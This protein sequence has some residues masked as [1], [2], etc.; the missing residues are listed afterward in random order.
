MRHITIFSLFCLASLPLFSAESVTV[1]IMKETIKGNGKVSVCSTP[2]IP[3]AYLVFTA[4]SVSGNTVTVAASSSAPNF[5]SP[6]SAYYAEILTSDGVKEISAISAVNGTTIT[7]ASATNVQAGDALFIRPYLTLDS[8]LGS[9]NTYNF[10]ASAT[11]HPAEADTV[12]IL[13]SA[14]QTF[15]SYFYSTLTGYVG[16]YNGTSFESAGATRIEPGSGLIFRMVGPDVT[17]YFSGEVQSAPVETR[18]NHGINLVGVMNPLAGNYAGRML[19]LTGSG[20]FSGSE[21]LGVKPSADG[22]A[23]TA[24]W[25]YLFSP[26]NQTIAT[27]FY[28]TYTGYVGW[29]DA[30]SFQTSGTSVLEAG[31]AFYLFRR[32]Q[33]FYWTQ[34]VNYLT[35]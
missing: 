33:A 8:L 25:V 3:S 11:G 9:G 15:S 27:H 21:S 13:D 12:M 6:L 26:A 30:T 22:N 28:S 10:R 35:N 5:I 1:G 17:L 20:L 16:W 32:G 14:S 7:L 29:Y 4:S 19:T 31:T 34:P 23:A 24:D 18:I 2:F